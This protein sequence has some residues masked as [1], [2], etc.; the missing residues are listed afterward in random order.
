[1]RSIRSI[2]WRYDL[3]IFLFWL[4]AALPMALFV[5][6]A[7][8]RGM[9]LSQ[10]GLLVAAY[11]LTIVLLEV[12]T[13]GLA[14]ALGR[15]RV[16]LIAEAATLAGSLVFLFSFSL[17]MFLLSFVFNG[18]GRAL[19]SGALDAWFVD[20]LLEVD[21]NVD[22]H[23]R[24]ARAGAITLLALGG[25]TVA[26][27]VLARVFLFLPP[28]GAAVLTPLAVPVVAAMILRVLLMGSISCLIRETVGAPHSPGQWP[29]EIA[30]VPRLLRSAVELTVRNAVLVRLLLVASAS[31]LVVSGLEVLWQPHFADLLGSHES[32][33]LL[34]GS[35]LAG[36]FL[37]GGI[38]NL[39]APRL[40][41]WLGGRNGRVC[42]VFHAL[43]GVIL[44]MVA[45]QARFAPAAAFLWLVYLGQGVVNSTHA[46]LLHHEIPPRRRS[47]MLSIESL[48][49]Y[50][51]GFLGSAGLGLLADRTSTGFAWGIAG[52]VLLVSWVL[53]LR[54]D[55]IREERR[56]EQE[57]VPGQAVQAADAVRPGG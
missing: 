42:A 8:A 49:A 19:S 51:G 14:D 11:S 15:K 48:A 52:G 5:L 12:P 29:R 56:R 53:Y 33:T 31:G 2:E 18:I 21:A 22:L 34:L 3:V 55:A 24:L 46:V 44:I 47:A 30:E 28:D 7:Q 13:G 41:R 50:L 32:R 1:M 16:A 43:R 25:G 39:F 26:G 35:V 45:A 20:T 4:A 54:V 23:P 6:L 57:S 40:S 17:P 37:V 27:G 38:G 9:S 10:I 36:C